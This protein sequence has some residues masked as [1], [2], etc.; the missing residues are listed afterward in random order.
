[1]FDTIIAVDWSAR[2]TPSPVIPSKDA[3]FLCVSRLQ[4]GAS[5]HPEYFRTR[6]DAMARVQALLDGEMVAGRRSF[7]GFDFNFGYP[8]GFAKQ[9]TGRKDTISVWKW[10]TRQ[11]L[12]F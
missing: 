12:L 5:R 9:L 6:Y 3:I 10:K 11:L 1:M 7:V 4:E 8:S 2:S